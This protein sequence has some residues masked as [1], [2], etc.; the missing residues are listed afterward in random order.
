MKKSFKQLLL[1][2][3]LTLLLSLP[4]F[5][6]AA[7]STPSNSQN[8]LGRLKNVAEKSY[9]VTTAPEQSLMYSVSK[10]IQ[11]FLSTLGVIFVVLMIYAGF[12]WMMAAGDADDVKKAKGTIRM[13]IIGLVITVSAYAIWGFVSSYLL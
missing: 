1:L 9:N 7:S 2:I 12:K 3:S 5:V 10:I 11:V 13:A 4:Y 8:T 6:F